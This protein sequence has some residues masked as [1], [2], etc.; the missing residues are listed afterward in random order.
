MMHVLM[1]KMVLIM[2]SL[3]FMVFVAC[4]E[5]RERAVESE[6][7][8]QSV[9]E[10]MDEHFSQVKEIQEAV[11]RG[12]LK[13]LMEPAKWMV[14][15]QIAEGLPTGWEPYVAQM[16]RASQAVGEAADLDTAASATATMAKTC[17]ACHEAMGTMPQFSVGLPPPDDAGTVPHMI[18]HMW[19]TDRMWEG[20]VI[21]SNESWT[22]GV[23]VLVGAPLHSD[24]LSADSEMK[25]DLDALATKVHELAAMGRETEGLDDRSELYGRFLA[26]CAR[27]HD[28]L[29][30]GGPP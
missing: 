24:D 29:G 10:H 1:R 19:A 22:N 26:T 12:D 25:D 14:E 20:L 15:H 9:G 27:C 4:G 30:Q 18:G 13:A 3:S 5:G 16:K 17:G 8:V 21:P 23:E 11:I 2:V 6:A 7:P 28:M